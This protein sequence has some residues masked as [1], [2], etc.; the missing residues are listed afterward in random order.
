MQTRPHVL[1]NV[2][3][4]ADGKIDTATRNGATISSTADKLRVDRLRAAS[5]AVMVGGRTLI[6]ENPKLTV[7]SG[8][9]R[10]E[11]VS[12]GLEENPAKVGI[13]SVAD[14]KPEGNFLTA[15][16]KLQLVFHGFGDNFKKLCQVLIKSKNYARRKKCG[17]TDLFQIKL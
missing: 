9:L 8:K 2:A 13:V 5:D 7:K 15:T 10:Q 14:L 12:R 4:T 11:R 1:V 6:K 3:M 17:K 16:K